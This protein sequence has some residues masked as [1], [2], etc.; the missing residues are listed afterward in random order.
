MKTGWFVATVTPRKWKK[1]LFASEF[2]QVP[3][4]ARD[5][6]VPNMN[7]KASIDKW[8][9]LVHCLYIEDEDWLVCYDCDTLE[10]KKR[11]LSHQ[12]FYKFHTT[13]G[14]YCSEYERESLY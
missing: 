4:H 12:N 6:I 10:M 2:L 8:A 11:T 3:Y 14:T 9:A 1:D 5:G 13:P 7:Q